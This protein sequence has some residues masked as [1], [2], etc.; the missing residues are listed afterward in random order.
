M[1]SYHVF[2]FVPDLY[3]VHISQRN[4][5]EDE[6]TCRATFG[7]VRSVCLLYSKAWISLQIQI[8]QWYLWVVQCRS[9]NILLELFKLKHKIPN[10]GFVYSLW[11][12]LLLN[13]TY[14]CCIIHHCWGIII[15]HLCLCEWIGTSALLSYR[16]LFTLQNYSQYSLS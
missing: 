16:S 12:V 4:S 14:L 11:N 6:L 7:N 2:F 15:Q 10:V 3:C 13:L 1:L 9:V 5:T 8:P